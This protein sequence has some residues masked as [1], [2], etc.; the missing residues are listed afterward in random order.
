MRPARTR[1]LLVGGD[2]WA[3]P[4]TGAEILFDAGMTRSVLSRRYHD[5]EQIVA[6]RA[7]GGPPAGHNVLFLVRADGLLTAVTESGRPALQA[8]DTIVSLGPVPA[9]WVG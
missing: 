4:Y 1:P 6:R 3:I 9:G 8:G 5:G 7:D 2:P